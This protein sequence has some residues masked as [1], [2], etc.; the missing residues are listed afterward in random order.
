MVLAPLCTPGASLNYHEIN[1][2]Q[3]LL[4]DLQMPPAGPGDSYTTSFLKT[5]P[6]LVLLQGKCHST[7]EMPLGC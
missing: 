3:Q 5:L 2:I 4:Q 7:S 6:N 1:V